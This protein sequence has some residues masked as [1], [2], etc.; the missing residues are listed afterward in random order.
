MQARVLRRLTEQILELDWQAQVIVLG[1][2]N[3]H[4]FRTPM[5]VLAGSRLRDLAETL[6]TGDRYS[7]NYLGNAQLLDHIF[8]SQELV[9]RAQARIDVVHINSDFPEK[10]RA[11]D[12]DPL[13]ARF[14]F[15]KW[16]NER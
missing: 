2:M 14:V 12:H 6:A 8:A 16:G 10:E 13:V 9:S 4:D 15:A 7:F 3:E 1:D 11:S 5:R